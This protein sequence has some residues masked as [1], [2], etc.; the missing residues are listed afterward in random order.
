MSVDDR[1]VDLERE[2]KLRA[3][4]IPAALVIAL[5][6]HAWAFGHYLQRTFLTMMVHEVGHALT[7]WFCGFAAIP[8]L[9][10]TLIPAARGTLAP[11]ALAAAEVTVC[12]VGVKFERRWLLALG[13]ALAVLQVVGT[14]GLTEVQAQTAIIFGGDGGAMVL[15]TLLM[16]S[17]FV[18]RLRR[19]G[20]RW[21]FV[22]IGAA[23][24]V[25]TFATWW[26]AR[27]DIGVIPFGEI[28]G[29]G[30]SDPSKLTDVYGW[31][32]HR[33]VERYVALG[34]GCLVVLAAVTAWATWSTRKA[35]R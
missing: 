4:V 24:Y 28:E 17:F 29:V 10:K 6:F 16:A 21:G 15:G 1:D 7:G 19:G 2:W 20:L 13:I 26:S 32:V 33:M 3:A 31:S 18:P 12:Y 9:W 22:A 34:V 23:A 11:I 25:D 8:T 14:F 5:A 30:L 27:S 35:A